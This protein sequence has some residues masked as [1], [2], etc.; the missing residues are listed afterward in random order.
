M[1]VPLGAGVG[2]RGTGPLRVGR[3]SQQG[4]DVQ[5][6]LG[7]VKGVEVDT[8]R[9]CIQDRV[10]ETRPEDCAELVARLLVRVVGQC[11]QQVFG[12]LDAGEVLDAVAGSR[13]GT[14]GMVTP[15]RR[16]RSTKE[17]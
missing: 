11:R 17:A 4:Q 12:D 1:V 13:P 3:D 7:L 5:D 14:I 10:D 15:A 6:G 9:A 2:G 8:G 16:A